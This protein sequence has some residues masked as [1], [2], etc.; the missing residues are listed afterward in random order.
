MA[1]VQEKVPE[2]RALANGVYLSMNFAIRSV[3]AIAFGAVGD[4]F[5]LRTAMMIS[6]LAMF[7]GLPIVW[8]LFRTSS[9]NR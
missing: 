6:A 4:A 8:L 7:L 1:L 5:G 3:G 9:T 2:S